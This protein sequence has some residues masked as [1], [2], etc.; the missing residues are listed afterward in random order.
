MDRSMS[1]REI[2]LKHVGNHGL[3]NQCVKLYAKWVET[4]TVFNRGKI[5]HF[6]YF[7][8]E[9]TGLNF[10]NFFLVQNVIVFIQIGPIK[11][12]KKKEG[13]ENTCFLPQN[14][15]NLKCLQ[16]NIFPSFYFAIREYLH[17]YLVT[18]FYQTKF[19]AGI[20]S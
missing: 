18:Y 4:G 6:P 3:L 9:I 12:K 19:F 8:W 13:L 20:N 5:S 17:Q 16:L 10:H 14:T 1:D 11:R 2:L 15:G 7:F